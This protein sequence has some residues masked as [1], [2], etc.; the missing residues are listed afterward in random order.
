MTRKKMPE[1]LSFNE[2]FKRV[3]LY[4]VE[5][6]YSALQDADNYR[7]DGG[8]ESF[9]CDL[10][11]AI[12]ETLD[13]LGVSPPEGDRLDWLGDLYDLTEEAGIAWQDEEE[14]DES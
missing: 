9:D 8:K 3:F 5:N 11:N 6:G 12:S 2:T 7:D 10:S 4:V 13:L 14:E 1:S